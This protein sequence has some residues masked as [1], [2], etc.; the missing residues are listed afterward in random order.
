MYL[1][2]TIIAMAVFCFA[3]FVHAEVNINTA[4]AQQLM[5][6]DNIGSVKAAEIVEYR[7]K[8][9]HFQSIDDLLEVSGIGM[10][11]LEANRAMLTVGTEHVQT[12]PTEKTI[13]IEKSH[14]TKPVSP[15]LNKE[16]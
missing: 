14:T 2:K 6:L 4:T 3:A 11:I 15:V 16:N 12:L 13:P 1:L 7:T 5:E 8:H 9:G 10:A